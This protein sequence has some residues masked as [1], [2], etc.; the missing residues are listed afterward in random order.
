MGRRDEIQQIEHYSHKRHTRLGT[1]K[2]VNES[3]IKIFMAHILIMSSVRK[4]TL[5]NYVSQQKQIPG[6]LV[7]SSCCRHN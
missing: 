7:E 2:D 1:W 6:H 4:P 5:H 3:D